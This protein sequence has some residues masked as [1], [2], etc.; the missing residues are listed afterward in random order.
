MSN[1]FASCNTLTELQAKRRSLLE[2]I[3]REYAAA[4][5]KIVTG[6]LNYKRV[7]VFKLSSTELKK[8]N[9]YSPFP[10]VKGK[11]NPNTIEITQKGV[12][13]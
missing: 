5:K 3:N 13:L 4:S 7:P 8:I 9:T 12:V 10:L 11:V 1:Y 2:E 6:V